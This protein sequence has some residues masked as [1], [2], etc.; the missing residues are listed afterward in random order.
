MIIA[1]IGINHFGDNERAW[2]YVKEL[3]NK[4]IDA[5]TFQVTDEFQLDDGFYEQVISYVH[6]KQKKL[7]IA[8]TE[9][10]KVDILNRYGCDFWKLLSCSTKDEKMIKKLIDTNKEVLVSTGRMDADA[11][12]FFELYLL[13]LDYNKDNIGKVKFIHT[14]LN[15]DTTQANLKRID[16]LRIRTKRNIGFGLHCEDVETLYTV[17]AFN[18]SDIF[19][20]VK[21]NKKDEFPDNKHAIALEDLDNVLE[22]LKKLKQSLGDG[23]LII[24]EDKL[25]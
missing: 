1:E 19:F 3:C 15:Q 8:I 9:I 16:T 22:K 11:L 2:G 6:S 13:S 4:D 24:K 25:E 23:E 21:D 12:N 10:D 20:Y 5:I 14:Q 17:V 18:P 7:G